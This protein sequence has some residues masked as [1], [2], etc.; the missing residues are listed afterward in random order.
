MTGLWRQ[1]RID[2]TQVASVAAATFDPIAEFGGYGWR[3]FKGGRAYLAGGT[4]GVRLKLKSGSTIVIGS[5]RPTDLARAIEA[6]RRSTQ[7]PQ[8][9]P[10]AK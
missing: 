1:D 10:N 2:A 4:T 3:R 9:A 7:N 8:N 5:T 6:A